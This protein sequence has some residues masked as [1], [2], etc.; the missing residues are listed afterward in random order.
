MRLGSATQAD[1]LR[2]T[3]GEVRLQ[4]RLQQDGAVA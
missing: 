1:E 4:K 2:E 3:A